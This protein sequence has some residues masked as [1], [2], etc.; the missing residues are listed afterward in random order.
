MK[1]LL[2][3]IMTLSMI[4]LP[5]AAHAAGQCRDAA[6]GRFA[7]CGSSGAVPASQYVA[8]GK[9]KP[10]RTMASKMAMPAATPAKPSLMSRLKAKASG[11]AARCRD[12]KSKFVKCGTPGAKPA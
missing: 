6:T 11:P 5:G 7:K 3:P 8:K 9:A 2:I 12:A 10:A 4:M 1:K